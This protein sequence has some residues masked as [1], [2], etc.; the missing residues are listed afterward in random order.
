MGTRR[1]TGVDGVHIVTSKRAGVPNTYYIYAWRGGPLIRKQVGG[2]RP[3]LTP[4]DAKAI[5]N[6]YEGAKPSSQDT[7]RGL[8]AAYRG[9]DNP[10][11]A[12][13]ADST[14]K[15]WSDCLDVILEKWG[16]TPLRFWSDPRMV[17]KV[18]GW[19]DSMASNPRKADNHVSTLNRLLEYGRLRA[20]VTV[21]VAAGIPTLYKG[22]QREEVIW[23]D[24]H[25]AA[26]LKSSKTPI[27]DA[28]R[29]ASLTGLRRSDLVALTWDSVGEWAIEATALKKSAG[30]RR[31]VVMPIVPG[32]KAL[33]DELRTR[34]R[35]PGV[36]TV[37]VTMFGD[38]WTADGLNSS[39]YTARAQCVDDPK[40]KNPKML[41]V[42]VDGEGREY[43]L[44]IHDLRGTFATKL[45]TIPGERLTDREIGELMG[46][47]ETQVS[48]IRRRYVDDAAI[49]VA[50]GKR[51]A[52]ATV[53]TAVKIPDGE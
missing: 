10:D 50:L 14:K 38:A 31:K 46:W 2:A 3:S 44:R 36:K 28:V 27:A 6:A 21:N 11:W 42:H 53:K 19:R 37:L 23:T 30:K 15:L 1:K 49:V 13:L 16:S 35:K 24:D 39:F 48:E 32:L 33:L 52:N 5:G 8:V 41:L 26:F 45:M 20:R 9:P 22:G 40:S 25:V 34:P 18:V 43:P 7:I 51:L 17:A 47:G 29:L 4:E 12:R